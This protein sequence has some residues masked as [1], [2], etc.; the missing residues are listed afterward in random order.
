[1]RTPEEILRKPA[2]S[3]LTNLVLIADA[4]EEYASQY[5]EELSRLKGGWI[6]VKDDQPEKEGPY[7]A[8]AM[9][10]EPYVARF[11]RGNWGIDGYPANPTHWQPLPPPP[12]SKIEPSQSGKTICPKCEDKGQYQVGSL[13]T[14]MAQCECGANPYAKFTVKIESGNS[15]SVKLTEEKPETQF[16]ARY[17]IPFQVD[18]TFGD[19]DK[20]LIVYG[21]L[22][23]MQ[24][25][26]M[27]GVAVG[28]RF[29]S[30]ELIPIT[31]EE[32]KVLLSVAMRS[33]IYQSPSLTPT[34]KK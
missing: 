16:V 33:P 6:S 1:M 32:A 18:G 22:K 4:M 25:L 7:L 14:S 3:G 12:A 5:K 9:G 15:E 2:Y 28:G 13:V 8:V 27:Q 24:V 29:P 34:D 10:W 30:S 23:D 20:K 26:Q 19:G 21:K 11:A 17:G 31:E